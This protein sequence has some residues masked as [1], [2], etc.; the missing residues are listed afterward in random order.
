MEKLKE[1]P[2]IT[3]IENQW[4]DSMEKL[5]CKW[6]WKENLMHK[7]IGRK[8]GIPRPTIIAGLKS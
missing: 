7:E 1:S 6:H 4:G 8:L 3:E 2:R 5:L